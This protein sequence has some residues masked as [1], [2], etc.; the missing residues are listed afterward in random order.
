MVLTNSASRSRNMVQTNNQPQAVDFGSIFSSVAVTAYGARN[1]RQRGVYNIDFWSANRPKTTAGPNTGR[2]VTGTR[3]SAWNVRGTSAHS[4]LIDD[5][6]FS[7]QRLARATTAESAANSDFSDASGNRMN[8]NNQY[9]DDAIDAIV[10]AINGMITYL[11]TTLPSLI[12]LSDDQNT[13]RGNLV[14]INFEN[15]KTFNKNGNDIDI[16]S[17]ADIY[18]HID[19]YNKLHEEPNTKLNIYDIRDINK[20]L[21]REF[22]LAE[23]FILNDVGLTDTQKANYQTNTSIKFSTANTVTTAAFDAEMAYKDAYNNEIATNH[24]LTAAQ[25]TLATA[26]SRLY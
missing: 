8:G 26:N 12:T 14:N 9:G 25:A 18:D 6:T 16:M 2:S 23:N 10:A 24:A 17:G 3:G 7:V 22:V 19:D 5:V 15:L 4:R 21:Q 13:K 1:R 11:N 20:A